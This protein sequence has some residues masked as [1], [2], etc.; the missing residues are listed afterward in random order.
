MRW[1]A[2]ILLLAGALLLGLALFPALHSGAVVMPSYL[3]DWLFWS[4]LPFGALPVVMLIDLIGPVAIV[5]LE[6]AL[7]RLLLLTPVA[8]V[9]MIPVLV[10]PAALFGWAAGHGFSAPFGQ[11]W[12]THGWFIERS[13]IYVLLWIILAVLF[14]RPPNP[15]AVERRRTF[16]AAGLCVYALSATLASVDWAMTVE[17]DWFSAEFGLLLIAAQVS[18]AVSVAV[19]LS[20]KTWHLIAP[21][22]AGVML[23]SAVGIW[24]FAQ[25]IQFLV[26]WSGN[27]PSDITWY[28][29]RSDL[30]SRI[31]VWTGFV[32][33]IVVP[34]LL[35][36][37]RLRRRPM[38]LLVA[39]FLVVC[40][41]ALGML[42][43]ITPSLRSY[44]TVSGMDVLALAGVGGL[45][46]GICLLVGPLP[47]PAKEVVS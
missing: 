40:T 21:D 39:A 25:F 4:S 16:A 29:H 14:R 24:L 18:I 20:G 42:W 27:K 30:G 31:A 33:G 45:M 46:L 43:L 34:I 32:I 22:A 8:A 23:I 3:A 47:K 37:S 12:M 10:Q 35:L 11:A 7:R 2:A 28:L 44:F 41:Q 36:S 15:E 5:P 9:L 19:L 26:I 38:V 6:L 17:P 1:I 13:I